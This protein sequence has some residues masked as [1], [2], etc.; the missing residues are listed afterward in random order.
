MRVITSKRVSTSAPSDLQRNGF[1]LYV[2][3][4]RTLRLA[5]LPK[6]S[7]AVM[8]QLPIGLCVIVGLLNVKH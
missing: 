1:V 4:I 7:A 8:P 6:E 5:N 3:T 2:L